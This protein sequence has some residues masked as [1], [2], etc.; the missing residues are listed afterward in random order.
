MYEFHSANFPLTPGVYLMKDVQGRIIYVGKAKRLR[1]RLASYFRNEE[2][3]TPKTRIMV[4][5]I[6]AVE[7][8]NTATEKEA[9]LLEASLIKKHRPRYNIVLRDDKQYVLMKLS[10]RQEFPRLVMTRRVVRDGSLYYGPFTSAHA[11]RQTWKLMGRMFPL[12]KC[13]DK[14]FRNRIRPCLY[15]HIGQCL[16]PCVHHVSTE[17]YSAIV[18]Q[19]ELFLSGRTGE[20]A[21]QLRQKM[22]AASDALDF[23]QAAQYRDQLK[24]IEATVEQ[25]SVVLS[26]GSNLD[27]LGLA[28]TVK[29]LGLALLFIRQGRLIGKKAHFWSG[30][31]LEEGEE[32]VRGFLSQFY[33]KSR[34]IPERILLPWELD[35]DT[36]QHVLED[37]RQGPVSLRA[38]RSGAEKKLVELARANAAQAAPRE[39][40]DPLDLRLQRALRLAS[41]PRR[42]EC[43]D[44]SHLGGQGMRSGCVVFED[45]QPVP[46]QYRTYLFEE[47]EGSGDDYAALAAWAVRRAQSEGPQP[48]FVLVDGGKGQVSAV[49]RALKDAG[50]EGIWPFAGIAKAS[51]EDRQGPDRRA[52]VLDDR[53]FLPGRK[54]PLPIRPGSPELLF[55]QRIRDAAH[56]F[57][58]GRQR[59]GRKKRMLQSELSS[60]PG[61]G[62][63]MARQLWEHFGSIDAM[64]KASVVEIMELPG[65]GPKKA[66]SLY[67]ALQHLKKVSS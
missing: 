19:V 53:I 16:G 7:T 48:D 27:V 51:A 39:T 5:K 15:Y 38:P 50:F 54:N 56:D 25:Q 49:S 47:L 29:G 6:S 4:S 63:A 43:V 28:E 65:F 41:P 42:I 36:I 35:D 67:T 21:T 9:L 11:A 3:Q 30:L 1:T 44:I 26:T 52:G 20:L 60:I 64:C 66:E 46:S 32:A 31:G 59:Q 17:T 24:A 61:I 13:G 2:R 40:D 57:V 22:L 37:F 23:E 12:R 45:G 55:L 10:K 8:L 14:M 58:I 62:P 18:R 33:S 34:F